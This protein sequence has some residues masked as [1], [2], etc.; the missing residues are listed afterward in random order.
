MNFYTK[1]LCRPPAGIAKILL[2]MKLIIVILTTTML[3]VSASTYAQLVTIKQRNADLVSVFKEIRRQTG[4]DFIYYDMMMNNAKPINLDVKSASIEKVLELCF[5]NQALDYT[6]EN[7]IVTIREKNKT[8]LDKISDLILNFN[9]AIDVTGKVTDEK[10]GA[11][12]GAT[13][14]LKETGKAMMTDANGEFSFKGIPENS[15]FVISYASFVTREIAVNGLTR[16]T[17]AL[18]ED[19]KKLEEVVVVGY[20]T[21]KKVSLTGSIAVVDMQTK[22]NQPIT[23][24]SQALHGVPGLWVNQ[25]GGQPGQDGASIRIRGI[26]TLNNSAPL[27]L[28]DGVEYSIGEVNPNDIENVTVLKDAAAAIYGSRAANGVVLITSKKGKIGKDEINYSYSHGLQNPTVLPEVLT[29]PIKYMEMRN[30][31]VLNEGKQIGDYTNGQIQEYR[32]NLGTNASIYPASDWFKI[33]MENGRIQQHNLSFRGGNEKTQYNISMGYMDQKGILIANDKANRFSLDLKVTTQVSK[34]LK[35]GA[36][37]TG[38]LRQFHEPGYGV[39]TVMGVVFRALPIMTDTLP[40]GKYGNSWLP[41]PGRNNYENPRMEIQEGSIFRQNQRFL[42]KIFAEY[43]LPFG[44]VYNGDIGYDKHDRFSKDYIPAMFTSNPKTGE[45]RAFNASVPRVRDWDSN[46]LNLTLYHTL[47]WNKI[48][49][50]KHNL[51]AMGGASY[52]SFQDRSFDAFRD[53]FFDNQLTELNAGATTN[54]V[55]RGTSS[56]DRLLSYFGRLNYAYDDKYLLEITSRY[57]G[58][59]RFSAQNR[60]S[61]FPSVSAG[62]RIDQEDFMKDSKLFDLLKLRL[63]WGKL[64]N[65]SV[66]LYSYLSVV[67]T[68]SSYQYSFGN[69]IQPGAAVTS[70]ND[71]NI[72]WE[73]TTTYNAGLDAVIFNGKMGI[74][75]DVFKRRTSGI[76]RA[77]S[78]PDQIGNL[79]GPQKNIGVV[80]NTGYELGLTYR[81]KAG[82]FGYELMGSINYVKN[83][84][85]NLDGQTIISGTRII[86]EGYPIDSYY[87]LATDGYYQNM[88]DINYSATVSNAVKPGYIRYKDT[89][90]NGKIDGDDRV[91]TGQSMPDYTF[92]FGI[93]LSYKRFSLNSLFQGVSGISIYPT[94]NLA[95]PFNNGA[96][97]T[98]EW[99]DNS[100]TP[101]N[102]NAKFPLLTTATG[103]T[104]N[105]QNSDFWLKDASYL[106]LQNIQLNYSIPESI[107][108]KV[109]IKK[110]LVYIN[111]QN[112]FTLAKYKQWDPEQK[113]TTD[114]LYEYPMLKT[115]S[116]GLNV[117]F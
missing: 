75:A 91:I 61:Y 62:W 60:W 50:Q 44:I 97:I 86:K 85:V 39:A 106:R 63:S 2:V 54:Q 52:I 56:Q 96:G 98:K 101:D 6:I 65:Q 31:A 99:V 67:N 93:N 104:E 70:Y 40:N 32:D 46:N 58:S 8:I 26:G 113:I 89:D 57:D 4:Y 43:K 90:R 105:F 77:V 14:R 36:G 28:L 83:K 87:L 80:D 115:V 73:T 5:K 53:G 18:K 42:T 110:A 69:L 37:V 117:N 21:Q 68:G 17:V 49:K 116:M 41:T 13:V 33:V 112:L 24:V 20:G 1:S 15:T 84:V 100:W 64:G 11:L 108:S 95:F 27:V 23:D 102:P 79:G 25:A 76:L 19:L 114:N 55:A 3:Q 107:L 22:E 45:E 103:G 51:S 71:P 10:G 34:N 82:D 111:G 66:P 81:D 72:S 74:T 7:K 109:R 92:S 94:A 30:Q 16:I 35:V 12:P 9:K 38:N 48:F 47:S 59:S 78:I 29:D 88:D